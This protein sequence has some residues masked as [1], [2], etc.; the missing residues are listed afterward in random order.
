[1]PEELVL[2]ETLRLSRGI[3]GHEAAFS[4]LRVPV[5]RLRDEILARARLAGDQHGDLAW[6]HP[7]DRLDHLP[8]RLRVADDALEAV[9]GLDLPPQARVLVPEHHRLSRALD[10]VAEHH[11][12]QWLDDEVVGASAKGILCRWDVPV[13]GHHDHGRLRLVLLREG[14]HVHA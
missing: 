4:S 2:K 13:G 10:K 8:D 1:V 5:N 11:Q 14:Q 12:V 7:A 9:R 3:E 6:G